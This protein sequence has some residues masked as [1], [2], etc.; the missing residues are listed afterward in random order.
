MNR[1]QRCVP[2]VAGE[3]IEAG[4]WSMAEPTMAFTSAA[5]DVRADGLRQQR[6]PTRRSR[7]AARADVGGFLVVFF[8][9]LG[10]RLSPTR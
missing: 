4:M 1:R 6:G 8:N 9:K 7:R 10:T 5:G 3:S 2:F